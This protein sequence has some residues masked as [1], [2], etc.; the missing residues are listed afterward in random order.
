MNTIDRKYQIVDRSS[1]PVKSLSLFLCLSTYRKLGGKILQPIKQTGRERYPREYAASCDFSSFSSPPYL[2]PP[3][4]LPF[5][6][7]HLICPGTSLVS[8]RL[9]ARTTACVH[10]CTRVC[11]CVSVR[12]CSAMMKERAG[13][14]PSWLTSAHAEHATA[15]RRLP[16]CD[17]AL[18][19]YYSLSFPLSDPLCPASSFSFPTVCTRYVRTY[20]YV[21]YVRVRVGTRMQAHMH[22]HAYAFRLRNEARHPSRDI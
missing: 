8:L 16:R 13:R 2:P 4:P 5:S 9:R 19:F 18:L 17:S 21:P 10:T 3:H 15:K 12:A 11:V 22:V 14:Q 7:N 20:V 6:A 1:E